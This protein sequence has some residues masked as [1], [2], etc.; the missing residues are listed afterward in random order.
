MLYEL[1]TGRAPIEGSS[2]ADTL[3]RVLSDEP[4]RPRTIA[5]RLPRDLEAICLTCLEK[6]PSRRYA[7]AAQLAEDLR[8]YLERQ[9][10]IARPISALERT[11]RWTARRPTTA[12]LIAVSVA[13]SL[14]LAIGLTLYFQQLAALNVDLNNS[15]TKLAKALGDARLAQANAE[16]SDNRAH[17]LLYISDMRL[18]SRAWKEGDLRELTNQ[19]RAITRRVSRDRISAR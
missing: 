12:A 8:R 3:R 9:P 18:A 15:N 14:V 6:L 16:A 11:I 19:L 2:H 4:V 10:T 7:N 13:A 17:E 1:L 5:P